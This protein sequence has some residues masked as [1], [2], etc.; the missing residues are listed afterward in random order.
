MGEYDWL[1]PEEPEKMPIFMRL[2]M[3]FFCGVL[4]LAAGVQI[5]EWII[6]L[7]RMVL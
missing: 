4:S 5:G 6:A 2:L 7:A 3:V 1:E